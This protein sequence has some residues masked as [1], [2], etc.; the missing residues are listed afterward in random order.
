MAEL[1]RAEP[2]HASPPLQPEAGSGLKST[3]V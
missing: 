1:L 3:V 2:R